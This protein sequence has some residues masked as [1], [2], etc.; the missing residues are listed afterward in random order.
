[1]EGGG[2]N[3]SR[4]GTT[5]TLVVSTTD[6]GRFQNRQLYCTNANTNFFSLA[7]SSTS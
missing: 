6:A 4:N 1:M 7:I 3:H 5:A 2:V